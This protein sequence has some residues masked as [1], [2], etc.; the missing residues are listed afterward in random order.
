M[1]RFNPNVQPLGERSKTVRLSDLYNANGEPTDVITK[2]KEKLAGSSDW[3]SDWGTIK[4]IA[5]EDAG[6]PSWTGPRSAQSRRSRA[7]HSRQAGWKTIS[8]TKVAGG[9]WSN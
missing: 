9:C 5:P 8:A 2:F 4:K 7:I 1:S 6:K 3:L